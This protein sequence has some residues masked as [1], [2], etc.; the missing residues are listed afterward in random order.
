MNKS[1]RFKFI[2][3]TG[4]LNRNIFEYLVMQLTIDKKEEHYRKLQ[5]KELDV[6]CSIRTK[7][8]RSIY[9]MKIVEVMLCY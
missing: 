3:W 6:P 7:E 2:R 8:L 9:Q 1:N 5:T 4:I